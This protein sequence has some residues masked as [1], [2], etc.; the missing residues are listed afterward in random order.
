MPT[1][2]LASG[3]LGHT[4]NVSTMPRADITNGMILPNRGIIITLFYLYT[5]FCT[6]LLKVLW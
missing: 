5:Q 2:I 6:G 3:F 1:K 4:Y